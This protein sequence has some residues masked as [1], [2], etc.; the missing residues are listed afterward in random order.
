MLRKLW[1]IAAISFSICWAGV[2][3]ADEEKPEKPEA[4]FRSP[5]AGEEVQRSYRAKGRTRNVPK[6]HVVILFR[7]VQESGFLYPCT[8]PFKGNRTFSHT[9]NHEKTDLGTHALHV[10]IVPEDVAKKI[11]KWRT[12]IIKWH[13]GGKKGKG[14]TF[15]Q[16]W[17][18]ETT[19]L[20]RV[21]YRLE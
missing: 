8:E 2:V 21:E 17:M 11:N 3:T 19:D 20:A 14:P 18:K 10:R 5:K 1:V 4:E 16:G 6:G 9:V 15:T 12:E 13:E 7:T